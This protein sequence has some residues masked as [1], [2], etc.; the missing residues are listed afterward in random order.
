[1][2]INP[3]F[4]LSHGLFSSMWSWFTCLVSCIYLIIRLFCCFQRHCAFVNYQ[5]VTEE[6]THTV[7]L[8]WFLFLLPFFPQ[9]SAT[10]DNP[11]M[12]GAERP[13]PGVLHQGFFGVGVPN[14]LSRP[15]PLRVV[16]VTQYNYF[17]HHNMN[18]NSS[19]LYTCKH[20]DTPVKISG[21][22]K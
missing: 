8:R 20:D 22:Y 17:K 12:P 7:F 4:Y 2:F 21:F 3:Q 16:Q 10:M 9:S 1:M 13:L 5:P 15:L 19:H 18:S 6:R 11:A 14:A